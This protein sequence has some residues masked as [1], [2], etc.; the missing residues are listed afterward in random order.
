M[1]N[2]MNRVVEIYLSRKAMREYKHLIYEKAD[3]IAKI[4][5]DWP[6]VLNALNVPLREEICSEILGYNGKEIA[7]LK[8]E[9][10][11]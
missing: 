7:A 1:A 4:I 2:E 11:I 6:E 8:K 5:L 9:G 3:G 10:I